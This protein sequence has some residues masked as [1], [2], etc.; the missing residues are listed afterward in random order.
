MT[1]WTAHI[2]PGGAPV[3]VREGFS[4]G[5]FLFGPLWLAGHRAWV[6]AALA[7]AAGILIVILLPLAVAAVTMLALAV[8]LGV[9]GQDFRRWSMDHRG[10][11]LTQ[12]IAAR[13]EP[14]ALGVLLAR[15]PDLV[16]SFLPPGASR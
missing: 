9:S 4:W 8:L 11:M 16:G 3:L 6:P 7:L 1:F 5:A 14:E 10:F 13:S 15:R 12:V 2:R